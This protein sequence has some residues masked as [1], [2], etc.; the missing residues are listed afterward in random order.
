M[1][2]SG[3]GDVTVRCMLFV[4]TADLP[5]RAVLE[6][7]GTILL[8]FHLQFTRVWQIK[9][10]ITICIDKASKEKKVCLQ[11]SSQFFPKK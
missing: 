3:D 10:I 6:I 1:P 11:R 8:K 4:A 5:A 9:Y 7:P 2:G